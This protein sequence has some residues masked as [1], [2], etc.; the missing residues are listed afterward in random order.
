MTCDI[1]DLADR[2]DG[3]TGADLEDLVRRAGLIALR[4][5]PDAA[6]VVRAH[7]DAARKETR[8][9]VT[10]EME[11]KYRQLAETLKRESPRGPRRIGFEPMS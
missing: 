9:S 4:D 3:F 5:D 1:D 11:R 8:A 10:E 6:T 7:F 2:T